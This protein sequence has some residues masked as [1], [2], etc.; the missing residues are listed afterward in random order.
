MMMIRMTM[1]IPVAKLVKK[2]KALL[3]NRIERRN[4]LAFL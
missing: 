1:T 3:N 4:L 2:I